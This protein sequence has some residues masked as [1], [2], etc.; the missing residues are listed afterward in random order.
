[1][2]QIIKAGTGMCDI[3]LD[4]EKLM[5]ELPGTNIIEDDYIT[6]NNKNINYL[7][8]NE[9]IIEEEEDEYCENDEFKFSI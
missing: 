1:M 5:S 7:L 9:D 8:K 6:G 4:E 2:G 3:Y